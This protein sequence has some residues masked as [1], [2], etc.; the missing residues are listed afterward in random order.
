MGGNQILCHK[1]FRQCQFQSLLQCQQNTDSPFIP[2]DEK[3][4]HKMVYIYT[5]ETTAKPGPILAMLTTT[6]SMSIVLGTQHRLIARSRV[7]IMS[8]V[9]LIFLLLL[10]LLLLLSFVLFFQEL[11]VAHCVNVHPKSPQER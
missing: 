9:S 4:N 11:V 5:T 8:D 1:E 7:F 3:G 6:K 10:L 2:E